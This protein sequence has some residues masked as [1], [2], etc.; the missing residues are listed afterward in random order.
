KFPATTLLRALDYASDEQI[1]NLFNL[2]EEV[3]VKKVKIEEY[4][5]RVIASD[6]FDMSTG[7]IFLTKDS[8]LSEEDIERLKEAEVDVLKF[9][10]AEASPEQ[11]LIVNTLKK[12]TSHTKEEALFAIYRQLRSGEAPDVETAQALIE[13][14]FFN[15]KRYDLGEVGR[16]RMNDKL[17]VNVDESITVLTPDDIL[18]IMKYIIKLKNGNE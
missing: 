5:G 13:K 3:K 7:E 9:I 11:D 18:A 12:D 10:K 16:H 2:V 17:K 4:I 6:V 8:V 1:L 15:D 14:M